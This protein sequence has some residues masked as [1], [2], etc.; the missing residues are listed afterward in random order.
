VVKLS[1]NLKLRARGREEIL[2]IRN[3]AGDVY[4]LW[5]LDSYNPVALK[6]WARLK[7]EIEIK[8]GI[9]Q[10]YKYT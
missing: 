8:Q 7:G 5:M 9:G 4:Y 2:Q 3:G 6:S 1:S 10:I